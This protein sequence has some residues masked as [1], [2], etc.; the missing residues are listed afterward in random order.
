[1]PLL[2]LL[3]AVSY[4]AKDASRS[5]ETIS[6]SAAAIARISAAPIT[7]KRRRDRPETRISNTLK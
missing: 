2:R 4:A 7:M 1:M 5:I 3:P 6:Q